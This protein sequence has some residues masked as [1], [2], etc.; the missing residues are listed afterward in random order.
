MKIVA[1]QHAPNEP[2][3][4][5]EKILEEK[6]IEYEYLKVYETN[7]VPEIQATHI[8]I[9]GGPMGVYD[10]KEYPFLKQEKE[11]LRQVFK[12]N[13]PVLG[14]CLGSQLIASALGSNVYPYM[15]EIGWFEVEKANSDEVI[16]RL[17][18]KI[19]VFQ[20]HNDTFNL[21]DNAKLLYT[22]KNVKNQAFRIGNTIG[23]QFHL[24]ITPEI[25]RNWIDGEKSLGSREKEKIISGTERYIEKAN[26]NCRKLVNAFLEMNAGKK[27]K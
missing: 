27:V 20:W 11:V 18:D 1:L 17:P 12:D 14:I 26:E 9:M 6:E 21:P 7:E 22:G 3:G 4:L 5:I 15:K 23:L 2:M 13:V 8:V 10:E 24:E 19:V 16:E 25:V